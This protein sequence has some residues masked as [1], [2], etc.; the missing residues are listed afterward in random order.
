MFHHDAE[1]DSSIEFRHYCVSARQ[2]AV[3]RGI[4]KLVNNNKLPNLSKFNDLADYI[5]RGQ[6]DNSIGYSS[7]SE[8][9]D[10]PGSKLVLPDD[11]QDKKKDT[12]VALRLHELGPRM[13]LKLIKIEEGVCRGNVVFHRYQSLTPAELKKQMDGLKN[14]R[15]LKEKRKRIQEENVAK[16]KAKLEEKEQK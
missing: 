12:S 10:L 6:R 8:V 5:L 11:F 16:K 3:N 9:E 13:K 15:E 14:K 7:E 2:R 4:K 1:D